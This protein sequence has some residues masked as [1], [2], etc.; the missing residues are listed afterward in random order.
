MFFVPAISARLAPEGLRPLSVL[1]GLA[2]GVPGSLF[3]LSLLPPFQCPGCERPFFQAV[4]SELGSSTSCSHCGLAL[5]SPSNPNA[6]F[7]RVKAPPAKS[8][9]AAAFAALSW[10]AL[11]GGATLAAY[12]LVLRLP[13]LTILGACLAGALAVTIL[14]ARILRSSA[15]PVALLMPI[16]AAALASILALRT[17]FRHAR[18]VR[19]TRTPAACPPSPSGAQSQRPGSPLN[20]AR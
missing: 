12:R 8:R 10:L 6:P 14:A 3:L 18:A 19:A 7:V 2:I 9:L 13:A 1:L 16:A 17:G 20:S 11:T 15:F 5:G 4:A